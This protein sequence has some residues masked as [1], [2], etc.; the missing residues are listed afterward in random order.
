LE[1]TTGCG[2]KSRTLMSVE[3]S[4]ERMKEMMREGSAAVEN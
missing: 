1:A 3:R 2:A 4:I